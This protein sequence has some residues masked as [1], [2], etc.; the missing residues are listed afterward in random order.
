MF[1]NSLH[2]FSFFPHRTFF[3][4]RIPIPKSLPSGKGLAQRPSGSNVFLP[5]FN[6]K[7]AYSM[8]EQAFAYMLAEIC[9]NTYPYQSIW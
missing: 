3:L 6:N 5:R 9:A 2:F 4:L 7:K 8:E 1:S